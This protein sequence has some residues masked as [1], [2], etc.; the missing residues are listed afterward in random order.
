MS[1]TIKLIAEGYAKL[2][3]QSQPQPTD[4]YSKAES[5]LEELSTI[6]TELAKDG[7]EN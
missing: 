6:L 1:D 4:K 5:M 3:A 2:S 7:T